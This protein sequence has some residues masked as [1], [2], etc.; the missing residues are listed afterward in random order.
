[1]LTEE[2]REKFIERCEQGLTTYYDYRDEV[3]SHFVSCIMA[4]HDEVSESY[5]EAF[6][7]ELFDWCNPND[8]YDMDDIRNLSYEVLGIKFD[9]L[10]DEDQEYLKEI[11]DEYL[12]YNPDYDHFL[13]QEICVDIF[14]DTGDY[15]YDL[16]C[17]EVYPHYNGM[18]YEDTDGKVSLEINDNFCMVWLSKTQG[19]SKDRLEKEL[20]NG[21]DACSNRFFDSVYDELNNCSSHMNALV[22]LK[23]MT[24]EEYLK[25]L[26]SKEDIHIDKNTRVGLFDK[27]SGAGGLFEISLEKD[28]DIPRS[29]I[30]EIVEDGQFKYN[31]HDVY[32]VSDSFWG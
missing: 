7:D 29:M 6:E 2:Q 31:V 8:C 14:V 1:M 16:G 28:I 20:I 9:D 25:M 19:Y 5:M 4:H 27:W 15:N 11:A 30:H 26:D 18:K 10:D 24:L 22:F 3:D 13:K 12:V 23:K 21:I 17:N 32:G